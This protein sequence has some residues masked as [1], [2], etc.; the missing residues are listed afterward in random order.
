M[1]NDALLLDSARPVSTV[2]TFNGCPERSSEGVHWY[3][4]RVT[5]SR[6]LKIKAILD[7]RGVRAFVPMM[8]KKT[9]E[10]GK[11]G[12]KLVPAVN[13]LC[14][15]NWTKSGIDR[16]IQEFGDKS[17]VYY[18]WDRTAGRPM[19]VPEKSMEDFIKV[20]SSMDEDLIYLTEISQKLREGQVVKVIEGPFKDVT[21]KIV[22]IKKNRRV[23]VELPGFLAVTTNH[24]SPQSLEVWTENN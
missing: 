6:E 21:G 7:E 17:P 16:F 15:V 2:N 20:S 3:V 10:A 1:L 5:Y 22:R 24:L 23:L 8:W 12:R 4:L 11:T 18:Y 13:N 14:F 9:E 19:T